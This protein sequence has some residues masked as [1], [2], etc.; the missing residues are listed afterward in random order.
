MLKEER[1][2]LRSEWQ[3]HERRMALNELELDTLKRMHYDT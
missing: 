3:Q 1:D 2:K